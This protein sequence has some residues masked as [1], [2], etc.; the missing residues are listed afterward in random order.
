MLYP[1]LLEPYIAE[2]V[3]GGTRLLDDYGMTTQKKNAAEAW[4]LSCHPDG[5]SRIVNGAFAGQSLAA[6]YAAHPEICGTNGAAYDRFPLLVKFIDARDDLSIQVH[7]DDAYCARIG[8]GEGKTEAWYILDCEPGAHLILGFREEISQEDFARAIQTDTLMEK[9]QSVPVKPGD[10]FFIDAG[11]L[12]A[13]CKGVL[14][15]E[16]Q[17]NSNTTFRIYDYNRP[18][19]DGKPRELHVEQALA[20]TRRAVYAQAESVKDNA[21]SNKHPLC[22]CAYFKMN[23]VDCKNGYASAAGAQAFVSLLV[24]KGEGELVC[25]DTALSIRKGQSVFLPAGC[26]AFTVNGELQ[27]LETTI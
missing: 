3:W 13:I 8:A 26:G 23:T 17:Q 24:L 10:F 12:H 19:M 7:P 15:A 16:V 21:L 20:V 6:L 27:L 2:L 25:G 22:D 9:L 4:V 18:G 11:T 1:M 14:L 5:E